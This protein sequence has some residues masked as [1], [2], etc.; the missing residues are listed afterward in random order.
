[1]FL[2]RVPI[3]LRLSLGY[4]TWMA[5]LFLFVGVGVFK[6]VEKDLSDSVDA[7]LIA[8]AK[9]LRRARVA[10]SYRAPF[11]QSFLREFF[12]E[13]FIRP[14]A[15]LVDLSGKV[16]SLTENAQVKLP[17]TPAAAARAE[18]GLVTIEDVPRREMPPMRLITMPILRRGAFT[19]E[20][21]QVGAPLDQM[22]HTLK[23]LKLLLWIVMPL[24]LLLTVIFG[25]VWM[26]WSLKPVRALTKAAA[27]LSSDDL[28]TRLKLPKARDEIHHLTVTFNQ[29]LDRLQDAFSRLRR[30]A[31]D[32][33]HELRTPL[34]VLRG[35][36]EYALR[37]DREPGVYQDSLNVIA[38]ESKHMTSIVEDLLL[39]ARAQSRTVAMNAEIIQVKELCLDL[40]AT[41]EPVYAER[42]I[43][44]DCRY[45][46]DLTF[47]GSSGYLMLALKNLLIN[48]AKHSP[49]EATVE[50]T[51]TRVGGEVEFRVK[52]V[53]AGIPEESLPY[54]FDPFYRADTAR[55]RAAGGS[56]IGLS[57]TQAL[58]KLH[59]GDVEVQSKLNEG[60]L[61][62]VSIPLRQGSQNTEAPATIDSDPKMTEL[63]SASVASPKPQLGSPLA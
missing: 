53:G 11:T 8:S 37:R 16:S 50:F 2:E 33:S 24:G 10:I 20:L 22:Y 26:A 58:I 28:D 48:A 36:A 41:L 51:A 29:M 62:T 32:V 45:D 15:Q 30:F 49:K 55:N 54:I 57:L 4:A 7:A 21:I 47:Y 61:F 56:G 43:V 12:G 31:G 17:V 63:F 40:K 60:S 14:Y 25:Y 44:L 5:L 13:N 19:G 52:D 6:V 46:E 59:D 35:E 34:T 38:S 39:L 23:S 27:N 42:S 9:S 1:M 3:R 18:A